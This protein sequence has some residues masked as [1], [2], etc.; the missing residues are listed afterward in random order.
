MASGAVSSV[1][2]GCRQELTAGGSAGGDSGMKA[3][4]SWRIPRYLQQALGFWDLSPPEMLGGSGA[5]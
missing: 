4:V 3:H 2:I 1:R 5:E